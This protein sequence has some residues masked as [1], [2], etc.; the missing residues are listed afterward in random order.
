M[1]RFKS[2][3]VISNLSLTLPRGIHRS[4]RLKCLRS[5]A[6]SLGAYVAMVLEQAPEQITGAQVIRMHT[7]ELLIRSSVT[8]AAN[9]ETRSTR[10][11]L[12]IP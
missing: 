9:D 6:P 8:G 1:P 4:A 10:G 12:P 3:Q 11:H 7:I 2:N 5:G